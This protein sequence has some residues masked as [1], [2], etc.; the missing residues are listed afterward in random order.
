[1]PHSR[2]DKHAFSKHKELGPSGNI[3]WYAACRGQIVAESPGPAVFDP[4]GHMREA[5]NV[6]GHTAGGE[7]KAAEAA[8]LAEQGFAILGAHL[9]V[10][11]EVAAV[12]PV[13]I[14]RAGSPPPEPPE[15]CG[16]MLWHLPRSPGWQPVQ[17]LPFLT[18]AQRTH[19]AVLLHL[20][21]QTGKHIAKMAILLW[22]PSACT[23][24]INGT[25]CKL[26]TMCL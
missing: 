18:Q 15:P 13:V 4:L 17:A 7:G 6:W 19:L 24:I 11:K 2:T 5:G 8:T 23:S 26:V 9:V 20:Q 21:H 1:M 14:D 16:R 3:I 25:T 10:L 12:V 22:I